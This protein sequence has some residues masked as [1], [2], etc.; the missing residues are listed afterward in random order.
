MFA[1]ALGGSGRAV[2][3]LDSASLAL[4]ARPAP[5]HDDVAVWKHI[6]AK[7]HSTKQV[8]AQ[9]AQV[10]AGG[11]P[12]RRLVVL[13]ME[14]AEKE[15]ATMKQQFAASLGIDNVGHL[16]CR[17]TMENFI[18]NIMNVDSE[19]KLANQKMVWERMLK[20]MKQLKDRLSLDTT[21]L[22]K[23]IEQVIKR[24]AQV[25][26]K[27]SLKWATE[28][29]KNALQKAQVENA[30]VRTT[31]GAAEHPLRASPLFAVPLEEFTPVPDDGTE[32]GM[33]YN[34]MMFKTDLALPWITYRSGRMQEWLADEVVAK[35][36]AS[37]G[38]KHKS[39]ESYE[40]KQKV[41]NPIKTKLGKE[42][43]EDFFQ[44]AFED[45]KC[46]IS[47]SRSLCRPHG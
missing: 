46:E 8:M 4:A 18:N 20:A 5:A 6:I 10:Q 19:E 47:T 35:N 13:E 34:T 43:T 31:K 14:K 1:Q 15:L 22:T 33:K 30:K 21:E 41:I 11:Q 7:W 28:A 3:S 32:L 29:H 17:R 39:E 38:T 16:R 36:M 27:A 42:E 12:Q 44:K 37:F 9:M 26:K 23:H 45:M 24:Q 25:A 2:T 40:S